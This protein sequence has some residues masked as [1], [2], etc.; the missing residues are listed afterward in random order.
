MGK[1]DDK[2]LKLLFEGKKCIRPGEGERTRG[3]MSNSPPEEDP[4]ELDLKKILLDVKT[5]LTTIDGKLDV[6]TTRLD[7]L[8]HC[9]DS[10]RTGWAIWKRGSPT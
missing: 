3:A 6:L 2:H 5:S 7:Q 1:T 4:D 10:T 9:V 8:K